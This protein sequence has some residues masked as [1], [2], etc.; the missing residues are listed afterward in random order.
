[1]LGDQ[2]TS[3]S[4]SEHI[5]SSTALLSWITHCLNIVRPQKEVLLYFDDIIADPE[6]EGSNREVLFRRFVN[7]LR[8]HY[9]GLTFAEREMAENEAVDRL[10][11]VI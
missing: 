11:F 10:V 7:G 1:M 9:T 4:I 2:A 3:Q 6:L 8:T 5:Q